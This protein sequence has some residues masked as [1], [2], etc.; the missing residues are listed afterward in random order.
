LVGVGEPDKE[1]P[2]LIA[3]PW[4]EHR[5]KNAAEKKRLID[6]LLEVAKSNSLT[7]AIGTVLINDSLP[8]DI[9]H[10]SKIFREQLKTWATNK[11]NKT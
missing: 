9:R 6:E 7:S 10:N 3:E 11:L 8:V 5:P 1:T 4:A 2:V